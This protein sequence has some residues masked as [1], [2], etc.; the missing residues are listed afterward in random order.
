MNKIHFASLILLV[1]ILANCTHG[2]RETSQPSASTI[3]ASPTS[4]A[5]LQSSLSTVSSYEFPASRDPTKRY[6][7]YLHGKIIEDQGI[8]AVSP[9]YGVYEYQAILEKFASYG[10]VVISEQR[11][12]NADGI[13]S[14]GDV[15]EQITELLKAGVID[16]NI[17]VVGASKGGAITLFISSLLEKD[18]V[19]FIVTGNC[20]PDTIAFMQQSNMPLHGNVLTIRDAMDDYSGS[21]QDLFAFSEGKGLGRHEEVV[22][23]TGAGHGLVYKALDEWIIPTVGWARVNSTDPKASP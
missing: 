14:A 4:I 21:C 15:V 3:S 17:T 7:F 22:L 1:V 16:K 23:H 20:D 6:L 8:H 12:K 11:P 13:K 2:S 10:F 18:E 19:N 9:E 5:T